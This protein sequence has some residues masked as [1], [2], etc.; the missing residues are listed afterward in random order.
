MIIPG[1]LAVVVGIV[2]CSS[3]N[4]KSA[5]GSGDTTNT[6]NNQSCTMHF[7]SGPIADP[8]ATCTVSA[9]YNPSTTT[10][11]IEIAVVNSTLD[12]EFN[13]TRPGQLDTT[14]STNTSAGATGLFDIKAS[15]APSY[16]M[17]TA[18][19]SQTGTF[20]VKFT[21]VS[22]A[23]TSAEGTTYSITGTLDATVPADT[24]TGATGTVTVHAT[25]SGN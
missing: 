11:I 3:S 6:S 12:A 20:S 2:A 16:E 13:T 17:T 9:V 5:G 14:T 15:G 4:D 23:S 25:F 10:S 19:G 8:N 22:V 21:K 18:P 1:V 7:T 24:T